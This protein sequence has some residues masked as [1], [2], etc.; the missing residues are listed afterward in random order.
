MIGRAFAWVAATTARTFVAGIVILAFSLSIAGFIY[1]H[2]RQRDLDHLEA[3]AVNN[4]QIAV[5]LAIDQH[6]RCTQRQT[7]NKA[8]RA[9]LMKL[10]DTSPEPL[11]TTWRT[12]ASSIVD[13]ECPTIRDLLDGS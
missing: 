3:I 7:Q 2:N 10:A 12:F 13:E 11:A 8:T 4:H 9:A 6:Q 1:D 5:R